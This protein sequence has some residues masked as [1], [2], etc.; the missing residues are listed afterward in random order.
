MR[1]FGL[2]KEVRKRFRKNSETERGE[3]RG[4]I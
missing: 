3:K 2:E 4:Q 1:I